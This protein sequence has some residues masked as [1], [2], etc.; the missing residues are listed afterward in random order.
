MS[1]EP[2]C[3][4][5]WIQSFGRLSGTPALGLVA[6]LKNL[7]LAH[8]RIEIKLSPHFSCLVTSL[9]EFDI[10]IMCAFQCQE[11]T[12]STVFYRWF[13]QTMKFLWP[14]SVKYQKI[15]RGARC[16]SFSPS[17][18]ALQGTDFTY[19]NRT[20]QLFVFP[21]SSHEEEK[22]ERSQSATKD[23]SSE[24]STV[25]MF[26]SPWLVFWLGPHSKD[27]QNKTGTLL[28]VFF[29]FFFCKTPRWN[30]YQPSDVTASLSRVSLGIFRTLMLIRYLS[31][32]MLNHEFL[33]T[34]L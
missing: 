9:L 21:V 29:F 27:L 4:F 8:W 19:E 20:S 12:L 6:R 10:C 1:W 23:A 16:I 34:F 25:E 15:Y 28:A 5:L 33:G 2:N 31:L 3:T 13:P 32:L 26:C 11:S 14:M 30:W 18:L 7:R 17:L 22:A 24:S